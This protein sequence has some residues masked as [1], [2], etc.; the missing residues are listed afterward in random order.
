MRRRAKIWSA[1]GGFVLAVFTL[2]AFTDIL[3]NGLT[4]PLVVDETPKKS[5]VIIV[6]GAGTR[7]HGNKLPPQAKQR[8]LKGLDL[9]RQ[10]WAPTALMS[11][12]RDKNT[13][14]VESMEMLVYGFA[15]GGALDAM[16]A[17][18]KS[19]DTFE[20]AKYSLAIMRTRGWRTA[21]V[22]TSP[23]HT[24][25]ACRIFRKQ[26]ADVRCVAAPF[27]LLPQTSVYE[28]LTDTRSVVRE[29]GAIVYNWLKR[30]L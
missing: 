17:E 16:A 19:K 3:R 29:Y 14:Y 11:G 2:A 21:I 5:D 15:Q 12:G 18:A 28:H 6:L 27:S 1:L 7:K 23:H 30:Q 13:G 8:V 20:N 25:R 10:G 9:Q 24:W 22:V 4:P 26:G